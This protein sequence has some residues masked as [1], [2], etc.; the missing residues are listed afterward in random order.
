VDTNPLTC[1]KRAKQTEQEDLVGVIRRHHQNL[2][3]LIGLRPDVELPGGIILS[4]AIAN[5]VRQIRGSVVERM[6]HTKRV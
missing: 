6:E 5:A 3:D 2:R 1:I 4:T